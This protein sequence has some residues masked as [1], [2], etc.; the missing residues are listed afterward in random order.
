MDRRFPVKGGAQ[1]ITCAKCG[2]TDEAA[3]SGGVAGGRLPPDA[4]A[5]I[6]RR[7]GWNIG[8]VPRKDRCPACNPTAPKEKPAMP[9]EPTP[10]PA[11]ASP[12]TP[13]AEPPRKMER[14]DRRIIFAKLEEVYIDENRG[15][16]PGWN[17][18]RLSKEMGVPRAW[19]EA[20]RD[21]NFGPLL[22]A[23]SP[24]VGDLLD[25]LAEVHA[26]NSELVARLDRA[27]QTY[28]AEATAIRRLAAEGAKRHDEIKARLTKMTGL[29]R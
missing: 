3:R 16:S 27:R 28:D 8:A 7:R 2:A 25:M 9:P 11:P 20:I 12:P 21:E 29:H 1:T 6:F 23:G 10:A 4:V 18:E 14:E 26:Q 15:Y 13:R 17:D 5:G 19:V 22:A 24:E